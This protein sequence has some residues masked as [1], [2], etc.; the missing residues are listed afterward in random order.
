MSPSSLEKLKVLLPH[1]AGHNREHSDELRRWQAAIPENAEVAS[2][3]QDAAHLLD[4]ATTVLELASG[5]LGGA[6]TEHPHHH[7]HSPQE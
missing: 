6:P 5:K 2:L 1:W 7:H 4:E 3:L